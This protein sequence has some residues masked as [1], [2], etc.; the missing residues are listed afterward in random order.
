[1][2]DARQRVIDIWNK[3]HGARRSEIAANDCQG[4][5]PISMLVGRLRDSAHGIAAQCLCDA[6]ATYE[7]QSA[8]ALL[9]LS[10]E[11]DRLREALEPF[12]SLADCYDPDEGDSDQ[13]AWGNNATTIGHL[14]RARAALNKEKPCQ[15]T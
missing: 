6:K 2:P 7:W 9:S 1:M 15:E 12:A 14:R 4:E 13:L 10:Q 3:R 11:R 8:D 5:D